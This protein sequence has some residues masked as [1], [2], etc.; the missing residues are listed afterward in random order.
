[1]PRC[2]GLLIFAVFVV[3]GCAQQRVRPE[4]FDAVPVLVEVERLRYMPVPEYLTE[5]LPVAMPV[6]RSCGE[7]VRVARERRTVI[8]RAN[9]DRIATRA[10]GP[11]Q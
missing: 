8:E 6:N 9:A 11:S 10:L 5:L 2:F 3:T 7:A 4:P 1:M